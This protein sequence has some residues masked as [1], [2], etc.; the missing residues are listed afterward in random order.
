MQQKCNKL[1]EN[2]V[3]LIYDNNLENTVISVMS[4]INVNIEETGIEVCI[5]LANLI[6][7]GNLERQL[8][9]LSTE[10]FAITCSKIK[11]DLQN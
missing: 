2:I 11:R 7:D 4:N 5:D 1:E 9:H 3:S 8:S 6:L 10:K